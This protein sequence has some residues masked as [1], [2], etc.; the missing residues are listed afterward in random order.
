[1]RLRM[2]RNG[3]DPFRRPWRQVEYAVVDLETTGLNLRH[4]SI[5]SYGATIIRGGRIIAAE[6]AYGL[7]RPGNRVSPESM[8]I[9]SLMPADLCDAP[10]LSAAVGTL[11]AM[12]AG[13]VLVAHAA[14]L[15]EAFLAR[16]FKSVGKRLRC[17]IIDTAVLARAAHTRASRCHGEPDLE[18]LATE[19]GLP[20]VSPHHALGDAITTAQVFLALAMR[21]D[22]DGRRTARDFIELTAVDRPW[23]GL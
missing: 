13:R 10:P 12:M 22:G 23:P 17:Q 19:V 6:N 9:H 20:A 5:V 14:W 7:V 18:V 15:E 1:M 16:A 4:D 8:T 3:P 21:I 2:R 11:G